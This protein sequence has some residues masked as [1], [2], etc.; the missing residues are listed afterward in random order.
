MYAHN[1]ALVPDAAGL[2]VELK[3]SDPFVAFDFTALD[4]VAPEN[5]RYR[6][7][8]H[9]FD[10]NWMLED[11]YGR[12]VYSNLPPG[13][14]EF[15]VAAANNNGVWN[16]DTARMVIV[17]P[18]PLWMSLQAYIL[19]A[20]VIVALL[21]VLI[22]RGRRERAKDLA[23]RLNLERQVQERTQALAEGYDQL[24]KLNT[25]LA[26]KSVTDSLTGLH[27]RRYVEGYLDKELAKIKRRRMEK[28][29]SDSASSANSLY[30]MMIDLDGFK[31]VNDTFEHNAGDE[32]L[33]QVSTMLKDLVRADYVVVR[34]GG[35]EFMIIGHTKAF[36]GA[37]ALAER[38]RQAL[39]CHVY[40]F[41]GNS[42]KDISCSIGVA[43][44]PFSEACAN[45][46]DW[47]H[48]CQI[49]DRGA[50]LAKENG[51]N[52]WVS[53]RGTRKLQAQDAADVVVELVALTDEAKIEVKSSVERALIIDGSDTA[54]A[55]K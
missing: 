30:F 21:Y 52:A 7:T 36:T 11:Q 37:E 48:V 46:L 41:Q 40:K 24:K 42:T 45:E 5:N 44:F 1:A 12:A 26:E 9:G 8:L 22:S 16:P 53:L 2:S 6:Y 51:R 49:A 28:N 47:E 35:D 13:K 15:E 18:P 38:I 39:D 17:V 3:K 34:W 4:F 43:P 54:V 55:A 19:Y 20:F 27:N 33:L 10:N 23:M 50:Y 25:R 14:Y 32:V 31:A 29:S